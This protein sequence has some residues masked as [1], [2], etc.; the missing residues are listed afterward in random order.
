MSASEFLEQFP[1][2]DKPICL[3][4]GG[5]VYY[6]GKFQAEGVGFFDER[7]WMPRAHYGLGDRSARLHVET[8]AGIL[9]ASV[10]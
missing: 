5:L 4:G 7:Y 10:G 9:F 3:L 1:R 8:T 2:T 6:R